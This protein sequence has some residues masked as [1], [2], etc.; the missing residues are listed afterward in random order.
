MRKTIWYPISILCLFAALTLTISSCDALELGSSEKNLNLSSELS[1]NQAEYS[2][3]SESHPFRSYDE[4]LGDIALESPDYSGH[5]LDENG[6]L[7]VLVTDM[8][9]SEQTREI[10]RRKSNDLEAARRIGLQD[11]DQADQI[12]FK[13]ASYSFLDLYNWRE[14]VRGIAYAHNGF[15]MLDLDEKENVIVIGIEDLSGVDSIIEQ[16]RQHSIPREAVEIIQVPKVKK[17]IRSRRTTLRGGLEI[18]RSGSTGKCTLGLP[19]RIISGTY[20]N[21]DGFLVNTHCTDV[22]GG[23]DQTLVEQDDHVLDIIGYEIL[24]PSF[25]SSKCTS[26]V[27]NFNPNAICRYSD[28]AFIKY[29]PVQSRTFKRGEIYRTNWTGQWSGSTTRTST[30]QFFDVV[31]NGSYPAQGTEL[32][33]VGRTT[34]WTYGYV[35]RTCVDAGNGDPNEYLI[36]NFSVYS[37]VDGGDSGSPV[38]Y[39]NGDEYSEAIPVTFHGLLWGSVGLS[40]YYFSPSAM[41]FQEIL[42]SPN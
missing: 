8:S 18:E 29:D 34:G 2:I 39:W 21:V 32:Q 16:L 33:K 15:S 19:S 23:L 37:G 41:I 11:S 28:S 3:T 24:D 38:F 22:E 5:Y 17:R 7:V 4:E 20:A 31:T 35:N 42:F 30:S 36:C 6:E 12:V 25:S 27:L 13:K 10:I 1:A 9:S 40:E 26:A 14:K